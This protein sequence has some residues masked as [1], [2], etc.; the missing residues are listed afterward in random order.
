MRRHSPTKCGQL[1]LCTAPRAQESGSQAQ[2]TS[3]QAL[4]GHKRMGAGVAHILA[5]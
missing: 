5:Q 4:Q 1:Q 2:G 3:I